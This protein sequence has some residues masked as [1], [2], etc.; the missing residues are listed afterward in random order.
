[1]MKVLIGI[2]MVACLFLYNVSAS[3]SCQCVC[4]NG[5]VRAICTN[6]LDIEP[7]CSPRICPITEPSI[8]PI[9]SPRIP[10]IGTSQCVQ[11]QVYNEIRNKY[12]WREVCY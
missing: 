10:P 4:M 12:E 3:A 11:R 5:E 8:S 9:Q 1:M 7:I 6:A 2:L